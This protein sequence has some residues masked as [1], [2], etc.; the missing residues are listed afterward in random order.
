MSTLFILGNGFDLGLGLNTSYGAYLKS[1]EFDSLIH[2]NASLKSLANFLKE[3][4]T[5]DAWFDMEKS[6]GDYYNRNGFRIND[7]ESTKIFPEF[8]R[9]VNDFIL[10][11]AMESTI[12][13]KDNRTYALI[14]HFSDQLKNGNSFTIYTY[15]Y[16]GKIALDTLIKKHLIDKPKIDFIELQYKVN[17]EHLHGSVSENFKFDAPNITL[18]TNSS[19]IKNPKADFIKKVNQNPEVGMF[20]DSVFNRFD[21]FVIY[22]HSLGEMDAPDFEMLFEHLFKNNSKKLDIFTKYDNSERNQIHSRFAALSKKSEDEIKNQVKK[23]VNRNIE[24][25]LL[26]ISSSY[27]YLL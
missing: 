11:T 16:T 8:L 6:I 1:S 14:E 3:E 18:G 13:F 2:S 21:R 4:Q 20:N 10:R 15:N 27:T 22:G 25:V 24:D 19:Y 5:L 26:E 23:Y 12:S 9:S 17:I 7:L